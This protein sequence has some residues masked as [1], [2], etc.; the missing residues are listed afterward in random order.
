MSSDD[1]NAGMPLDMHR[2]LQS[3]ICTN[4]QSPVESLV[5]G[6]VVQ[7]NDSCTVSTG[8]RKQTSSFQ[9]SLVMVDPKH[10]IRVPGYAWAERTPV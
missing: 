4:S 3:R 6:L 9:M 1:L 7:Q 5:S 10:G 2:N 8:V